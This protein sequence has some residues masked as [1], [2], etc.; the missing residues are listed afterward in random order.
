MR[1]KLFSD[2]SPEERRQAL[3]DNAEKIVTM[4][5]NR[6]FTDDEIKEFKDKLS[7]SLIAQHKLEKELKDIKAEYA[8]EI[9]P[10]KRE[11]AAMAENIR[12]RFERIEGE[13]FQ[14]NDQEEGVAEFY[15]PDGYLI[16]SRGL[17]PDERQ[18]SIMGGMKTASNQ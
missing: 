13:C 4:E 12:N 1:K 16:F 6:D 8:E 7:D 5:Y 11:V 9:K 2:A 14:M 15:S 10:L 3:H 18:L 17:Y